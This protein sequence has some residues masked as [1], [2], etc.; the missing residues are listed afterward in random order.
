MVRRFGGESDFKGGGIKE[1]S[2]GV[3]VDTLGRASKVVT[4]ATS[5]KG[6]GCGKCGGGD[7]SK[8]GGEGFWVP[9]DVL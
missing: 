4:R 8:A 9:R 7:D 5:S 3:L 2:V 6:G 1:A